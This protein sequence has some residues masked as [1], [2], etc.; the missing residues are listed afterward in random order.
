MPPELLPEHATGRYQLRT[1]THG[2]H[3]RIEVHQ[4]TDRGWG[5]CAHVDLAPGTP[6][7]QDGQAPGVEL[8]AVVE[9]LVRRT[10]ARRPAGDPIGEASRAA[11]GIE[12]VRRLHARTPHGVMAGYGTV[13]TYLGQISRTVADLAA[14]GGTMSGLMAGM[15]ALVDADDARRDWERAGPHL[16]ALR[17]CAADAA[18]AA[19]AAAEA[20]DSAESW[21]ID[22]GDCRSGECHW[23]GRNDGQDDRQDDRQAPTGHECGCQRHTVSRLLAALDEQPP[24]ARLSGPLDPDDDGIPGT[25]SHPGTGPGE[26]D[27]AGTTSH[28]DQQ[29]N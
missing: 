22:C 28:P 14:M 7:P 2:S 16:A 5:L 26:D 10:D 9:D 15:A 4:I 25:T 11:L 23:G 27:L 3:T 19:T 29:E 13:M 18:A 20:I 12:R 21:G 6:L 24:S 17:T 1:T 8:L